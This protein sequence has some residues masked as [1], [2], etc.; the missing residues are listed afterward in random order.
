LN[1][2]TAENAERVIE[3]R[4]TLFGSRISTV[5]EEAPSL[6]QTTWTDKSIRIPPER[7]TG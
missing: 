1:T 5:D 7:R 6:Q 3:C 4:K 2:V